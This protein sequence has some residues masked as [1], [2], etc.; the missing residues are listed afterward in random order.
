MCSSRRK[1]RKKCLERF[2]IAVRNSQ[3]V[4]GILFPERKGVDTVKVGRLV[5]ST[6]LVVFLAAACAVGCIVWQGYGI[7]REAMEEKPLE[8]RVAEQQAQPG[9]TALHDLP[10]T[11]LQAVV[12]VE[13]HRFYE[14]GGIDLLAMGRA[15]WNDLRTLSFAEGGSTITQQLAKNLCF[16]QEKELSRKV[17]EVFA[18]WELE[19]EYTKD[20]I[21]EL[22]VNSIYY[23]SG[24]YN[25]GSA[26]ETYFGKEP[27]AMTPQ[28]CTLL[29]GVPNAPSVYDPTAN[30]DLAL[31]RQRQVVERMVAEEVLTESQAAALLA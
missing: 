17:A 4:A 28:E 6:L 18:A 27:G 10:E 14:H 23:G 3:E 12:A 1:G 2:Q 15:L 16:S 25:V 8:Q 21:L 9:Y 5:K 31:Q 20:E 26:S 19:R 30:P 29:A 11:Y 22:Y 7:Y 24:C 13:D